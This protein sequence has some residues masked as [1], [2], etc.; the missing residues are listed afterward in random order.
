MPVVQAPEIIRSYSNRSDTQVSCCWSTKKPSP[1]SPPQAPPADP[2]SSRVAPVP[3][4]NNAEA[5]E[6]PRLVRCHAVRRDLFNNWNFEDFMAG[7]A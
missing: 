3:P 6:T 1:P 5:S 2:S 4:R 7:C